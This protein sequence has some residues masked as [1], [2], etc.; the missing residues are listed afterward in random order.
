MSKTCHNVEGLP[1]KELRRREIMDTPPGRKY[2]KRPRKELTA[3]EIESIVAATK[4]P[5]LRY[6]EVAKNFRVGIALVNSLVRESKEQPEK[7]QALRD[8][9]QSD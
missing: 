8:R 7:V 2:R 3:D 6:A 1:E 9:I 4:V 5:F